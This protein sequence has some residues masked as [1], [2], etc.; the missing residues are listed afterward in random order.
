MNPGRWLESGPQA[1]FLTKRRARQGAGPEWPGGSR[2]GVYLGYPGGQN[3]RARLLRAVRQ[4][5]DLQDP[6]VC[7]GC[8]SEQLRRPGERCFRALCV[9]L[10]RVRERGSTG[11]ILLSGVL[12]GVLGVAAGLMGQKCDFDAIFP[13]CPGCYD[14]LDEDERRVFD[15][16]IEAAGQEVAIRLFGVCLGKKD[17]TV[18]VRHASLAQRLI[19]ANSEARPMRISADG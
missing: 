14:A 18:T 12:F 15:Q 7:F 6:H 17:L 3:G 2:A 5:D 9:K 8:L 13:L 4:N 10:G 16:G 11:E 1:E 19:E